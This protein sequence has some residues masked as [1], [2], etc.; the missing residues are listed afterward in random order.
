MT[1]VNQLSMTSLEKTAIVT[2]WEVRPLVWSLLIMLYLSALLPQTTIALLCLGFI[3]FQ[4]LKEFYTMMPLRRAERSL[5]FVGYLCIPLQFILVGTH[6]DAPALA[7]IPFLIFVLAAWLIT[8][9]ESTA[10]ALNSTLK[11]G[12]GLFTLVFGFSHLGLLLLRNNALTEASGGGNSSGNLLLYLLVLVHAQTLMQAI[13]LRWRVNHWSRPLFYASLT[14]L[15]GVVSILGVGIL[16]WGIGP[17]LL[18]LSPIN[19]MSSGVLIGGAAYLGTTT[20]RAMQQAL[21]IREADRYQLGLGGILQYIYPFAYAAPL[22]F[23][24]I[25]LFV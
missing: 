9:Y 2:R 16:A 20:L 12:W 11:L 6:Y 19:A 18:G 25:N 3:S 22:F 10:Q 14:G 23:Y 8:R 17:W 15:A 13:L 1:E 21:E 5:V 7:F 4:A 24:Y